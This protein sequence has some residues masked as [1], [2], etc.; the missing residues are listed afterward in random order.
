MKSLV[1]VPDRFF[2]I[3]GKQYPIKRKQTIGIN[4]PSDSFKY[5]II[6]IRGYDKYDNEGPEPKII[7]HR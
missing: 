7:Y 6:Y 2:S 1:V 5:E 4:Q 3:Y